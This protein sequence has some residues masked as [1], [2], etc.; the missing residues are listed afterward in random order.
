MG[1]DEIA[2]DV[3]SGSENSGVDDASAA[4]DDEG[5]EDD[6]SGTVELHAAID[7]TRSTAH[8]IADN[9]ILRFI[10]SPPLSGVSQTAEPFIHLILSTG[11]TGTADGQSLLN[12]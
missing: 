10:D 7:S 12:C 9:L 3:S 5:T 4:V 6:P 1:S 8:T 11:G 2:S